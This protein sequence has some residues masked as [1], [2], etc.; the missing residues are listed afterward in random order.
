MTDQQIS[1]ALRAAGEEFFVDGHSLVEAAVREGHRRGRRRAVLGATA[2]VA[3]VAV[4]GAGLG[5]L[6]GVGP[7]EIAPAGPPTEKNAAITLAE[8]Q[9]YAPA[10]IVTFDVRSNGACL[11]SEQGAL[12]FPK[13]T[14]WV[15]G[16]DEIATPDGTRIPLGSTVNG[17]G[18][19][20]VIGD[21]PAPLMSQ[22]QIEELTS[23]ANATGTNRALVI[24]L[25]PAG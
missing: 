12:V 23:C 14:S 13:G 16:A 7:L 19:A 22:D 25:F 11:V 24:F 9:K 4:L 6:A 18:S 3:V 10:N 21:I 8:E 17:A 1:G 5:S 2:A 20:Y 15:E